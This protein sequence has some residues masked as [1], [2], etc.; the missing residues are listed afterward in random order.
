VQHDL[1]LCLVYHQGEG[2][3]AALGI[4]NRRIQLTKWPPTEVSSGWYIPI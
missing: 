2:Q 4:F 3:N 1:G